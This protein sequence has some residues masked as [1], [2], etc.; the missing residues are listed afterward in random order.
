MAEIKTDCFAYDAT[1]THRHCTVL[2]DLYCK[3]EQCNFYKTK[4][5]KER[6]KLEQERIVFRR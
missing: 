1:L 2:D 6:E 5:Q 3:N 4:V